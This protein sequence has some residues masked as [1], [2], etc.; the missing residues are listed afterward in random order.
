[1]QNNPH[2]VRASHALTVADAVR[3]GD[4][5]GDA[6]AGFPA[7]IIRSGLLATLAFS[8]E[9][10]KKGEPKRDAHKRIADA[11]AEHLAKLSPDE[12]LVAPENPTG[13]GL[14]RKLATSDTA[15]LRRCTQEALEF[16]AYLKRFAR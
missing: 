15:H 7:L 10:N 3:K 5:E 2:Q 14:L 13:D 12:N 6:I 4:G 11:I 9:R 8:L 1:M 16:L